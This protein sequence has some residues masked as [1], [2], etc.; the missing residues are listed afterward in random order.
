MN[1][2]N[3]T[4]V[5]QDPTTKAYIRQTP[6]NN[7][8]LTLHLEE[9]VKFATP[10]YAREYCREHNSLLTLDVLQVSLSIKQLN[11][12][13]RLGIVLYRNNHLDATHV[14]LQGNPCFYFHDKDTDDCYAFCWE[15]TEWII[16]DWKGM[17]DLL[18]ISIGE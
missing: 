9:A 16:C 3:N 15:K 17:T 11:P 13:T 6:D 8:A 1:D 14:G 18:P 7:W 12:I 2:G 10:N 4:F 5:L